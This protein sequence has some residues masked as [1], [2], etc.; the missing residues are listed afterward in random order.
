LT[1]GIERDIAGKRYALSTGY[2]QGYIIKD[3]FIQSECEQLAIKIGAR[4][5]MN[6]QCRVSDGKVFVFEVHPRFSGTSS[7][8]ADVGFN[9]PDVLIRNFCG[10]E[11]FSRLQYRANVA[12]IRAFSNVIVPMEE[13]DATPD[14]SVMEA[15]P[16][17]TI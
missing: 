13:L 14:A 12:A 15:V 3:P 16:A 17:Q 7:F 1:L 8:R 11:Q 10:N 9:E 4:G 5:P 2:S 6:I